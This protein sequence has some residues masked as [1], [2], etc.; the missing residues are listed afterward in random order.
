MATHVFATVTES[1][2]QN[3][4]FFVRMKINRTNIIE[5]LERNQHHYLGNY[6]HAYLTTR[7]C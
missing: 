7:C 5:T 3:H 4:G 2:H 6:L 1:Y